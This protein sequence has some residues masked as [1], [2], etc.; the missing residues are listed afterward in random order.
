[1]QEILGEAGLKTGVIGKAAV[2]L[3]RCEVLFEKALEKY[4]QNPL[5]F[6]DQE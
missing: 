4:R 1:V 3:I 5:Y 2:D 6:V